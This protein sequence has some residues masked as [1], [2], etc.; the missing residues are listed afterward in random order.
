M[1]L[2]EKIEIIIYFFQLWFSKDWWEY[3][4]KPRADDEYSWFT[5]IKCRIQGHPHGVIW[6]NASGYEPNM[7]CKECGDDRG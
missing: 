1:S 4:L 2:K 3:L 5:V 7:S 6:Y